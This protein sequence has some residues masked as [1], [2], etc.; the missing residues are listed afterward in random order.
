LE[1]TRGRSGTTQQPAKE[2]PT[3]LENAQ[4]AVVGRVNLL[5]AI[6]PQQVLAEFVDPQDRN[7][8]G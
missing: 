8:D 3:Q 4:L 6:L 2:P 7:R 5:A 1:G